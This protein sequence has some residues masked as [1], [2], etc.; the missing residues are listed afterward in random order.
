L[1]INV[2]TALVFSLCCAARDVV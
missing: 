2:L 1:K